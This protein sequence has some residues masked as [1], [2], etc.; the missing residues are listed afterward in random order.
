MAEAER[1]G[2]NVVASQIEDQITQ[3]AFRDQERV[4][5]E[6]RSKVIA[7]SGEVANLRE[8]IKEQSETLAV[9]MDG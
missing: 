1:Y 3:E 9:L 8:M 7:L 4:N 2:I 6:L 5:A